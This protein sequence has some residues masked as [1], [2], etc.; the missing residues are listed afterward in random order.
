MNVDLFKDRIIFKI[1]SSH[2]PTQHRCFHI[3][4]QRQI[5]I[6]SINDKHANHQPVTCKNLNSR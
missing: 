2:L 1:P 6:I 4:T 5:L 3:K